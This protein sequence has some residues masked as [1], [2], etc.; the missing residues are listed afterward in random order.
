MWCSGS[1]DSLGGEDSL[2]A[3]AQLQVPQDLPDGL[4]AHPGEEVPHQLQQEVQ[5]H[6]QTQCK[7]TD[8]R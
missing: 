5:D 4:R 7:W 3:Q 6:L 2:S 1:S 8:C